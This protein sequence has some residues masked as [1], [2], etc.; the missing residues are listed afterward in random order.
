M[1]QLLQTR[2]SKKNA[3]LFI[4]LML[5]ALYLLCVYPLRVFK[6]DIGLHGTGNITQISDVVDRDRDAGEYFIAQYD[7][8]QSAE[9]YVE[10]VLSGDGFRVMLFTQG[11]NGAMRL[12]AQE[13]VVIPEDFNGQDYI[14]IPLDVDLQPGS[15]NVM[16]ITPQEAELLVGYEDMDKLRRMAAEQI[17]EYIAGFYH[18]TTVENS[19]LSL[20]MNYRIAA[21]KGLMLRY[22]LLGILAGAAAAG[23][24]LLYFRILPGRN[25]KIRVISAARTVL[26][27]A[28]LTISGAGVYAVA[29]RHVFDKRLPDIVFY[30]IGITL[31]AA[32]SLY[33]LWRNPNHGDDYRSTLRHWGISVCIACAFH[34]S[35]QYTNAVYEL[36]HTL[37]RRRMLIAILLMLLLTCEGSAD[38]GIGNEFVPA[39]R[40]SSEAEFSERR[41]GARRRN[42][43]RLT[44]TISSIA[45]L[46]IGSAALFYHIMTGAQRLALYEVL[47]GNFT[48]EDLAAERLLITALTLA[49]VLAIQ[50]AGELVTLYRSRHTG[51]NGRGQQEKKRR[52]GDAKL[53]VN[54]KVLIPLCVF[55][56][57]AMIFSRPYTSWI[58]LLAALMAAYIIRYALFHER[59]AWLRD[60]CRGIVLQFLFMAGYSVLH[61]YFLS[62]KFTRYAMDFFTVTVTAVYLSFVEAAALVLVLQKMEGRGTKRLWRAAFPELVLLGMVSS[63]LLFTMSRTGILTVAVTGTVLIAVS[64]AQQR[65]QGM[66][67][68][69]RILLRFLSVALS[70]V[71]S[72]ILLF[73]VVFTA[74]RIITPL[75]GEPK[76]YDNEWLPDEIVR[77]QHY[78]SGYYICIER[79]LNV[80]GSR[81]LNM[82][83]DWIEYDTN[84]IPPVIVEL[85]RVE[86]PKRY[87][88]SITSVSGIRARLQSDEVD[89][90]EL[91]EEPEESP[92]DNEDYEE[93]E[94]LPESDYSNGRVDIYRRYAA[95]LNWTGH[96]AMGITTEEGQDIAHA[97]NVFLQV[98]YDFGI[99]AGVLFLLFLLAAGGSA[100]RYYHKD[101]ALRSDDAE[102]SRPDGGRRAGD[103]AGPAML[104]LAILITFVTSGMVE[105]VFQVCHPATT[106]LIL[107]L[108]PLLLQTESEQRGEGAGRKRRQNAGT[109]GAA[110]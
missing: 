44:C 31:F 41:D 29:I 16:I 42:G 49:V 97:H 37:S 6:E 70:M 89:G 14:T 35:C 61:R 13:E 7:H 79:F 27:P 62:Y 80:F 26:T 109:G 18:D 64:L 71:L 55:L 102:D 86:A 12:R 69:G 104:P 92:E 105:W 15:T 91:Y 19:A 101:S 73:P 108:V 67:P 25:R 20:R 33:A 77:N 66:W 59:G 96:E 63:Y 3:V 95:L 94:D 2:V 90:T 54:W 50:T 32:L 100:I 56:V 34:F 46:A 1:S 45:A 22:L 17:P 60:L 4:I 23:I 36:Q 106:L 11:E 88:A 52:T 78:D 38:H 30:T 72:V 8:L 68:R 82:D 9:V 85:S 103:L 84:V 5:T 93:L 40:K 58:F 24:V 110:S 98:A 47:P 53:T 57:L 83:E 39:G 65:R 48:E 28:V 10:Q 107:S 75:V 81:V 51:Q 43:I 99:P 21:R 87:I 76:L 74:H